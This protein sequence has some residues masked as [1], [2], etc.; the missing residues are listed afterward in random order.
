[1]D[2]FFVYG[3]LKVGGYFANIFDKFRVNS[4]RAVLKNHDL[5]D[6]GHFPGVMEGDGEVI[7]EIH[8]YKSENIDWILEQFDRIEGYSKT[9]PEKSL[10]LRKK[11]MV[12]TEDGDE[13]AFVY[14]FNASNTKGLE[15]KRLSSGFWSMD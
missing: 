13:K 9:Q 11:L 15:S 5:Y 4:K 8:E 14:I 6:L 1:M 12:E 10:Y 3:T 7:G 2:K